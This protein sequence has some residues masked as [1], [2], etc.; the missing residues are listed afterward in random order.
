MRTPISSLRPM[1]LLSALAL[2]AAPALAGDAAKAAAAAGKHAPK[3]HADVS[4]LLDALL[5]A[6]APVPYGVKAHVACDGEA[7]A[8]SGAA[9]ACQ[10][11]SRVGCLPLAKELAYALSGDAA[12]W[13]QVEKR[14]AGAFLAQGAGAEQ[15]DRL[16][17]VLAMQE[18]EPARALAESLWAKAPAAFTDEHLVALAES[19]AKPFAA[20]LEERVATS[21]E[22]SC[23]AVP[24]AL[25]A[26]RGN[27]AGK[28]HLVAA[29]RSVGCPET[30]TARALVAAAALEK[31]GE[32]G[33]FAK[34]LE[35]AHGKVLAALDA[36]D[37]AKANALTAQVAEAR[38]SLEN[39]WGPKL[40]WLERRVAHA[41]S[42]S[43]GSAD[44]DLVYA[45][46]EKLAHL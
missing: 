40:A 45:K 25:L 14:F 44:A 12:R 32:K 5:A 35:A 9:C 7:G 4:L 19:G 30:G 42:S 6:P 16:V 18:S 21:K 13:Q 36:G 2:A 15:R 20:R 24:A 8:C 1:V 10:D 34:A 17:G 33:A 26:F 43:A 46:I 39:P 27:A 23:S 29:T 28:A 41:R 31:L 11:P 22:G 3:E 38:A 37:V